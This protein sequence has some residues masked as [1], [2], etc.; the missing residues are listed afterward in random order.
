MYIDFSLETNGGVPADCGGVTRL[1]LLRRAAE[2]FARGSGEGGLN[3]ELFGFRH[4]AHR[5]LKRFRIG[6]IEGA[7]FY[8]SRLLKEG[9][10]KNRIINVLLLPFMCFAIKVIINSIV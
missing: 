10:A 5:C 8:R 4:I 2:S 1:M 6:R 7:D 3:A 9:A